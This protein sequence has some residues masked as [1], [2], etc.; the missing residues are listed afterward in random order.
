MDKPARRPLGQVNAFLDWLSKMPWL[1]ALIAFPLIRPYL[2][3]MITD[4]WYMRPYKGL[5]ELADYILFALVALCYAARWIGGRVKRVN[6]ALLCVAGMHVWL[7]AS[8]RLQGGAPAFAGDTCAAFALMLLA[9]MG[10]RR[11]RKATVNGLSMALEAWVYLNVLAILLRPN[12][13]WFFDFFDYH[14]WVLGNRVMY[15]RVLLPALCLG[16]MNAQMGCKTARVRLCALLLAAAY[17][18]FHQRGG[19]G[20]ACSALFLVLLVWYARRALPKWLNI[21]TAAGLSALAFALMAL[22]NVQALFSFLIEDVLGKGASLGARMDAWR[23]AMALIARHPLTGNGT[24]PV[25]T[26]KTF[27]GGQAHPHNQMLDILLR[28]GLIAFAGYA[29]CL[30]FAGRALYRARRAPAAKTLALMLGVLM[31]LGTIET[32]IRFTMFYPLLIIASNADR[33]QKGAPELP[34]GGVSVTLLALKNALS[35]KKGAPA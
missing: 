20:I 34:G 13:L 19:M 6:P 3:V 30:F 1:A 26:V 35:R 17:T 4:I 10:M 27:L 33:L 15:Y 9:D 11:A 16:V 28:G 2:N 22:F 18:V 5:W 14:Y 25:E 12:G 29:G 8:T 31:L 23:A 21:G 32:M 24:W 7:Y